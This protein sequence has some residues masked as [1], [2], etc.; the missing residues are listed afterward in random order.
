MSCASALPMCSSSPTRACRTISARP[1]P[2]AAPRT[3]WPSCAGAS[4]CR[5]RRSMSPSRTEERRLRCAQSHSSPSSGR[6]IAFDH[7]FRHPE[8]SRPTGGVAEGPLLVG[9]A[10]KQVPPL[11]LAALGSGRDDGS[12]IGILGPVEGGTSALVHVDAPELAV[13]E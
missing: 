11:R 10:S 9:G 1:C 13:G 3:C 2:S 7:L 8:R 6:A 5:R 4:A 12:L